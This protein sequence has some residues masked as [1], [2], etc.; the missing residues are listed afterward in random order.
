MPAGNVFGALWFFMLFLAAITSSLSMLQPAKA[1]FQEALGLTHKAATMLVAG[2]GLGGNV[3][4]LYFSEGTTFLNTIDF[5]IGTFLIFVV[6][7][8]Q[9]ICFA[10]IFGV[11]KGLERAHD[12]AS[13]RIPGVFRFIMKYVSPTFLLIVFVMFCVNSLPG[14][15]TAIFGGDGQEAQPMA[16]YALYLIGGVFLLLLITTIVGTKRWRA[17]GLDIDGAL[18]PDDE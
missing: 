8:V 11:D 1:F 17:A 7:M 6:A 9:I 2:I 16:I 15:M 5:W 18:P 13:I 4:V 10:W 14:Q 3:L 12:G